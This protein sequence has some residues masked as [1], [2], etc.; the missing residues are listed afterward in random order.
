MNK[1]R[2]LVKKNVILKKKVL[3][4]GYMKT[5]FHKI[6]YDVYSK[7]PRES[8]FKN[9]S[10]E[11]EKQIR[12]TTSEKRL[13]SVEVVCWPAGQRPEHFPELFKKVKKQNLND[14]SLVAD[15]KT[16]WPLAKTPMIEHEGLILKNKG[17]GVGGKVLDE[18]LEDLEKNHE[19]KAIFA[20]TEQKDMQML[21]TSRNFQPP[22]KSRMKKSMLDYVYIKKL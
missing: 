21:L 8:F 20:T 11:L 3:P 22:K 15:I 5:S 18:I 6:K 2:E 1:S 4:E 16:F 17:R 19:V 10:K 12:K 9:V 13:G 7:K 14:H